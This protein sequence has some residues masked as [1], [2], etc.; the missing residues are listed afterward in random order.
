MKQQILFVIFVLNFINVHSQEDGGQPKALAPKEFSIP[1]SPVFDLMGVTPSQ[2][3]RT[4]DIKDFK[5]DWSF[6]SWRLNP[7]LAI[8]SQPV[9]ELLY[10]R[11]DLSRYQAASRFMRK[12]SS[13]DVSLGTVQNEENDRRIGGAVKFNLVKK[14]DPLMQTYLYADI[15][16]RY[17]DE[18]TGLELQLKASK[19][20]LDST[21]NVLEKPA[22]REEIKSITT[23]L[24][25]LNDR[26]N[27]EIND[28]ARIYITENWNAASLDVAVGTVYTYQTDSAGSLKKLRLNR[29]TGWGIWLNG[30]LPLGKKWMISGLLRSTWYKEELNF[31]LFNEDTFQDSI[32]TATAQ[33]R[34]YSIGTNIR[35]GGARYS[36]FVEFLYEKRAIRTPAEA[37]EK[38]FTAPGDLEVVK[39]SVKWT[40]LNPNSLSIGGDW[41]VGSRV[42]INYGMRW[43]MDSRGKTQA[44]VPI[45]G[46]S[47]MMR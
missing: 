28:R 17:A 6:K 24:A 37:L 7:N 13:L 21:A 14:K 19:D 3:N 12:L 33:N 16:T 44:F 31:T 4:S 23:Q 25:T 15:G 20:K 40:P 43:I 45:A 41:R 26:R 47:C 22:L 18:K 38:S 39:S 29:N 10:N 11:K 1:P 36:F 5:V 8:Q 32:A 46:I 34:I 35:Y 42:I 9:W 27:A 30:G 2:V